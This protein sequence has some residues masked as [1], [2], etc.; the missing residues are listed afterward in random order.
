[1]MARRAKTIQLRLV[2]KKAHLLAAK[3][4]KD[5][6]CSRKDDTSKEKK[7]REEKRREQKRAEGKEKRREEMTK[8]KP[9]KAQ[10]Q[11]NP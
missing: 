5:Q 9:Q 8:G 1:M 4:R 7:R 10:K 11:K 2:A 6:P 3:T